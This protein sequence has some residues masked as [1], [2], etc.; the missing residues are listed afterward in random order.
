MECRQ[1]RNLE[2]CNCTYSACD[3]RG[4]CCECIRYHLAMRQLPGCAFPADAE[5]T[6]D[7]S[8]EHFAKLVAAGRV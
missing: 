3:K 7:R 6:Y 8:F 2:H 1:E 4:L 5:R